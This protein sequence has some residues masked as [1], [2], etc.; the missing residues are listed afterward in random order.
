MAVDLLSGCH[1]SVAVRLRS[2][3]SQDVARH[4]R[5]IAIF[6]QCGR[7]M[8]DR[9]AYCVHPCVNATLQGTNARQA[10]QVAASAAFPCQDRLILMKGH[11]TVVFCISDLKAPGDVQVLG[12]RGPLSARD[13]GQ[14]FATAARDCKIPEHGDDLEA[15]T[16]P[17][18]QS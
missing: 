5:V 15:V 11:A 10:E 18:A 9:F 2:V 8:A 13:P 16:A 3:S 17:P 1:A 14:V 7:P 4:C 12:N 6:Y